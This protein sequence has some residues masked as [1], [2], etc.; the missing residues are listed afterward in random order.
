MNQHAQ[1]K[2]D[3]GITVNGK[4]IRYTLSAIIP[5]ANLHGNLRTLFPNSVFWILLN[6]RLRLKIQNVHSLLGNL[7]KPLLLLSI[8]ISIFISAKEPEERKHVKDTPD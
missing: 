3:G 4:K 2:T 8:L 7:L 5:L 1:K 6:L